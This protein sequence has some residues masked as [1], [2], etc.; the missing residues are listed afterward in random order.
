MAA[1]PIG[2]IPNMMLRTNLLTNTDAI[3]HAIVT[4]TA[5]AIGI[6]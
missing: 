1:N 3:I 4:V 2:V 5:A 6:L